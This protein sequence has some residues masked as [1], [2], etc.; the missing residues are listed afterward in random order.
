MFCLLFECV[1]GRIFQIA[2]TVVYV[3]FIIGKNLKVVTPMVG[4]DGSCLEVP[5]YYAEFKC[6]LSFDLKVST[7]EAVTTGS[8]SP[9]QFFIDLLQKL[10]AY[11]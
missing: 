3:F 2:N 9:F 7:M 10:L 11:T 5:P 8:D 4:G 6:L 1:K